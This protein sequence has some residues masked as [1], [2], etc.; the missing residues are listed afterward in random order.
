MAKRILSFKK[1]ASV[2]S[3]GF[4]YELDVV[5]RLVEVIVAS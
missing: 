4:W 1:F 3:S 2:L 5:L